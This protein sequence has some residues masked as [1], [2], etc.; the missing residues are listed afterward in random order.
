MKIEKPFIK[1]VNNRIGYLIDPS[2]TAVDRVD[3]GLQTMQAMNFLARAV[4]NVVNLGLL[5]Y[6][7]LIQAIDINCAKLYKAFYCHLI[8]TKANS[9]ESH[10]I[11]P[12]TL[13]RNTM[14]NSKQFSD[15][16]R[17]VDSNLDEATAFDGFVPFRY[18]VREAEGQKDHANR[19]SGI[20]FA[21]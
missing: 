10:A 4:Q 7:T 1:N 15:W 5:E 9:Y 11:D 21:D 3:G 16:L 14:P 20:T 18:V 2:D 12:P 17:S 13:K 19:S 8:Q 6:V